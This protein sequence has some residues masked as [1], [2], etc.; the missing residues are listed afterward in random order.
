MSTGRDAQARGL[1]QSSR[2]EGMGELPTE[3]QQVHHLSG[4][5]TKKQ[6]PEATSAS[7]HVDLMNCMECSE[8]AS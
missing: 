8:F 6:V 5:N 3:R 2:R 4:L 1:G 7:L